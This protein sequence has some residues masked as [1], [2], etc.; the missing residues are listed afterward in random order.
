MFTPSKPQYQWSKLG[1]NAL[2]VSI[3][4]ASAL[5]IVD[6]IL[7]GPVQHA[8][9]GVD[10]TYIMMATWTVDFRYLFEQGILA[11]AVFFIGAMFL[12]TRTTF[13]IGFDKLDAEKMSIKGPDENN[14]VWIGH[15]YGT[16]LEA[17]SIANAL[18]ERLKE[19]A[20]P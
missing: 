12:E 19:S 8:G 10:P 13:T 9:T 6:G 15:R 2:V 1:R 4:L 16:P 17:E 3:I 14:V 5:S 18:S 7:K 11:A 20:A